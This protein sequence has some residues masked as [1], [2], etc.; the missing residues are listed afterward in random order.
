MV[1]IHCGTNVDNGCNFCR[2]CGKKLHRL[3]NCWVKNRV[4][5]CGRDECPGTKLF[6][7]EDE[8]AKKA[9]F[10]RERQT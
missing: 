1:C 8:A 9:A 7:L 6:M 3:C 2:K 10:G 4:Y 5:N